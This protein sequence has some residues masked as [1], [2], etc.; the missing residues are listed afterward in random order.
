M[1]RI[2][3]KVAKPTRIEIAMEYKSEITTAVS[4]VP[5]TV[6]FENCITRGI[7]SDKSAGG[8]YISMSTRKPSEHAQTF[9]NTKT[10]LINTATVHLNK[11]F[12]I[13]VPR[14]YPFVFQQYWHLVL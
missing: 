5:F 13:N 6:F 7:T 1:Q 11:C 12:M 2:T 8:K 4:T 9:I 14:V 3:L 10:V